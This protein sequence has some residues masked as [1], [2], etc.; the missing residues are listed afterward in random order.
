MRV[1]A[2]LT[3][4]AVAIALAT[5]TILTADAK[6]NE[7]TREQIDAWTVEIGEQYEIC[8]ELIQAVIERESNYD[9]DAN[10]GGCLGL[11]QISPKWHKARMKRLGVDDLSDPYNNILVGTD[12]IAEL[13]EEYEDVG[14]VLMVY[15]G[16]SD[17]ESKSNRGELSSY[18]EEILER[19]AEL[20]RGHGK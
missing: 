14:L 18:A 7:P 17:A 9:A 5:S 11:M 3:T 4:A 1:K 6:E 10:G 20:E 12:Y 2:F 19:S 16:E 13:A 15:H 8:P